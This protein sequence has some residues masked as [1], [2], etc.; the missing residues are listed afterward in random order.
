[1]TLDE[2]P[3]GG[4]PL[5]RRADPR[6]VRPPADGLEA[7]QVERQGREVE[8]VEE[9]RGRPLDDGQPLP[10]EFAVGEVDEIEVGAAEV[11]PVSPL[12]DDDF[13]TGNGHAGRVDDGDGRVRGPMAHHAGT[14][15][16]I[17][18][19]SGAPAAKM[20]G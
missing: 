4:E 9:R 17:L 16:P 1:M 13:L 10:G 6:G 5:G 20:A 8:Q 19:G 12:G 18:P 15:A 14:V 2:A 11:E 7:S 3:A